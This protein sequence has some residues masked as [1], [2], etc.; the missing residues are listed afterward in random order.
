MFV[1][2]KKKKKEEKQVVTVIDH[3]P[4]WDLLLPH[5]EFT[6]NSFVNKSTGLSPFEV[7]T[8]TEPRVPL[9]LATLPNPTRASEAALDF[10]HHIQ[11]LHNEVRRKLTITQSY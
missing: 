11:Q 1:L 9:D 10:F 4:S 8:G 3:P 7:V 2:K 5:A 6:Y